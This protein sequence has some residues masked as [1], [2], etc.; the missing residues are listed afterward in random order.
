MYY[1]VVH[2]V[3][4]PPREIEIPSL[5]PSPMLAV[6]VE[7]VR[8][9][10][11][12]FVD[13]AIQKLP[14]STAEF[15]VLK[16]M[17]E[18]YQKKWSQ[19]KQF[20]CTSIKQDA[21]SIKQWARRGGVLVSAVLNPVLLALNRLYQL[22]QYYRLEDMLISQLSRNEYA[23][24]LSKNSQ[25]GTFFYSGDFKNPLSRIN[26]RIEG[27]RFF[28]KDAFRYF[29]SAYASLRLEASEEIQH[30]RAI[31]GALS[32]IIAI[33]RVLFDSAGVIP[34]LRT[35]RAYRNSR[36]CLEALSSLTGPTALI[37]DEYFCLWNAL[38]TRQPAFSLP[39]D[40]E[41][42]CV[43]L[44]RYGAERTTPIKSRLACINLA[45]YL[46]YVCHPVFSSDTILLRFMHSVKGPNPVRDF[47]YQFVE[48]MRRGCLSTEAY[49]GAAE[50]YL[51][52]VKDYVKGDYQGVWNV[53]SAMF[54][55]F[56]ARGYHLNDLILEDPQDVAI[57][58]AA[59]KATAFL[60]QQIK[61]AQSSTPSPASVADLECV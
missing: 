18:G 42:L 37:V 58:T 12:A 19:K 33:P 11:L 47:L 21:D 15:A 2:D 13:D 55:Q 5:I 10:L 3:I 45:L 44:G 43:E 23:K 46:L 28:R 26:Q 31:S 32:V 20:E 14:S 40:F 25:E 30:Q 36:T 24:K 8:R 35:L 4:T 22:N 34:P 6:M 16:D 53:L 17:L 29:S 27:V 41:P 61:I 38:R 54:L 57:G 48:V 9:K 51:E 49:H 59:R 1:F 39:E 56:N 60:D 52:M 7:L 50:S